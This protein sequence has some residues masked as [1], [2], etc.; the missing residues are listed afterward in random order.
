MCSHTV[1]KVVA[2][3]DAE[4]E[5]EAARDDGGA[6][7]GGAVGVEGLAAEPLRKKS[8]INRVFLTHSFL[9]GHFWPPINHF[10]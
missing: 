3:D 2:G 9:H 6:D 8:K 4:V 5:R 1:D 7:G 10:N